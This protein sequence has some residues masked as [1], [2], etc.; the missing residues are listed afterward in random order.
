MVKV[1]LLKIKQGCTF[2]LLLFSIKLK[3]LATAIRQEKEIKCVHVSISR[4]NFKMYLFTG[5][6]KMII[7]LNTTYNTKFSNYIVKNIY[8]VDL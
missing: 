4:G 2:S 7:F 3:L 1:Y 5:N 6:T 8:V